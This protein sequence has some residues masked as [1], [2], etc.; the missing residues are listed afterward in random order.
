MR[1]FF[2][3]IHKRRPSVTL[4]IA[5]SIDGKTAA[6]SGESKWITGDGGARLRPSAARAP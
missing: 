3:H 1:G 5:Q 4:K 6:A 2:K